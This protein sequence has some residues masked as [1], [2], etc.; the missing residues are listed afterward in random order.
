M[1]TTKPGFLDKLI[2]RLSRVRPEEAQAHLLRLVREKG[3]FEAIFN[4]IQEGI[5]VTDL[6]GKI[7]YLNESACE[8]F[9]LERSSSLGKK[10]GDKVRG[11]DWKALTGTDRLVSRDMQILY[12]QPRFLNFYL[13]PLDRDDLDPAAHAKPV[14]GTGA[15]DDRPYAYAM[16]VRDITES[17]RTTEETIE[18]ERFHALTLL[19]AGVAHEIGNPLN[20]LHIHL[21]LMERKIRKLPPG[22]RVGLEDSVRVAKDEIRRLDFIVSQFLRAVRPTIPQMLRDDVNAVVRESVS[23]LRAEMEDRGI[24]VELELAGKLPQ[25]L[26]DRDQI[27]QAFYNVIKNAS[28]AMKTAGILRIR[29]R[30]EHGQVAVAFEDTGGGITPEN[31]SKVFQPYFTTKDSGTGLGL[32]IVRRIVREHGGEVELQSDEGRGLTVTIRLP[33]SD[34]RVQMLSYP[35]SDVAGPAAGPDAATP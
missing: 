29:T 8:L 16:I 3:F 22:E 11:L 23:F 26:V 32:M 19:A 14:G 20:S 6:E 2:G 1:D 33:T 24:L 31:L 28:Q 15:R 27:K 17:R 5:I 25:V 10:L 4:T 21:Q 12:P 18:S 13:V 30:A 9:G 7:T 35:S 34:R